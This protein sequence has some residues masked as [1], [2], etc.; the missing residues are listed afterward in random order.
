MNQSQLEDVWPLSPTQQGLLFH[1]LFD[2]RAVDAYTVQLVFD[3]DGPVD[4]RAL[5]AAWEALVRRHANLR[6]A[7]WQPRSGQPVQ[8][9]TRDVTVPWREIDLADL[10][11][12]D[13]EASLARLLRDDRGQRFDL[14]RPPLLRLTLVKVEHQTYRLV[15]THHHILLD[16]WSMQVLTSEL[17]ALYAQHGDP[18]GLAPVTPYRDYLAWLTNQDR[19]G[20]TQAW[21][22]A[23]S[24]LREPTRLGTTAGARTAVVAEHLTIDVP[25]DI[26]A[27]L[28]D[29]ARRLGV[30]LNTVIQGIWGLLLGRLT[31]SRDVVFGAA[32]NGRPPEIPGVATMVG[33]FITTLPVRIRLSPNES[34]S[35]M[36]TRLQDEQ[37]RLSA[38]HHLGLS[39]IQRQTGLGELFDT[40]TVFQNYPRRTDDAATPSGGLRISGVAFESAP[41]YPLSLAAVPMP[42]RRLRLR[43]NY[44][45]DPTDR[46]SRF[47]PPNMRGLLG[48][49]IHLLK[50]IAEDSDRPLKSYSLVSP[51]GSAALPDPCAP[52]VE[53][54]YLPVSDMI[55]AWVRST[56][57]AVAVEH[58]ERRYTYAELGRSADQ[59]A[60]ALADRGLTDGDVVAVYGTPSPGLVAAMLA[61]VSTGGVLLTLDPGLPRHR[62]QLMLE[63]ANARFVISVADIPRSPGPPFDVE[64]LQVLS[65]DAVTAS[66]GVPR[67]LKPSTPD[68]TE[69]AYVFFTSG[70]TGVPKAVVGRH[71]SLS[72]FLVWQRDS[73]GIGPGDRCAQLTGLSFDVLLR[74]VFLPLVSGATLCV[75]VAD[76]DAPEDMI[77]WLASARITCVHAVPTLASAWLQRPADAEPAAT[78]RYAFF[79][80]EA[81]TDHLVS[82]WRQACPNARVINLYGPSETTLAK[83]WY[84]VP[85]DPLPGVQPLGA[86]LPGSQALVLADDQRLCG[87]GEIGE[88]VVRSPYRSLGYLNLP[89]DSP[90]TFVLNKHTSHAADLLYHTG[91]QGRYRLDGGLEFLGRSDRQVKIRGVRIEPDEVAATLATHSAVSQAIVATQADG[92]GTPA[93]IAYLTTT[94]RTPPDVAQL[95]RYLAMR[96]PAAMMPAA[97]VVLDEMP[98]TANGKLDW[99]AL[100]VPSLD[101]AAALSHVPARSPVEEALC[102][103][104]EQ[105][106]ALDGVG[107]HDDFF[108]LGGHSLLAM[109]V[110]GKVRSV[111]GMELPVRDLFEAPTVS[112]LAHRLMGARKGRLALTA[113]ELPRLLPLSF[114]QRRLWF[115]DQLEKGPTYHI[116]VAVRL[117]GVVN[118]PALTAAVSDVVARHESVRTVFPEI[119]G[120]A[121]QRVV[122][123]GPAVPQM[124]EVEVDEA[125]LAQT[126]TALARRAFD[127]RAE[128]PLRVRLLALG[129]QQHVLALVVH[130]IAAD[131]WSMGVLS[132]DLG[133]AYAAR[134]RGEAPR[135]SALSVHYTDYTMWQY[136]LLGEATDPGSLASEQLAYWTAAL[137]ELPDQ[138]ELPA[139]RPRPATATNRGETMAFRLAPELHGRL[140]DVAGR[141]RA[142]L[143]MALQAGLAALLTRLGAGTDIPI[144]SPIAGRT[145]DALDALVGC[146]VNTL[147]LRTDTSGSPSFRELLARVR[148]TNLAAY[149][150]QDLPFEQLVEVL[151]PARSLGRHP[152][153]QVMLALHNG[154]DVAFDLADLQTSLESLPSGSAR[155]DLT[156]AFRQSSRRDCAGV[157]CVVEY[158]T[159]IFDAATVEVLVRRLLRLLAAAVADPDRP[160]DRIDLLSADE[161]ARLLASH[162]ASAFP[163]A[164]MPELFEAQVRA[165]PDLA[166]VV[167]DDATLSYRELNARANRL[168]HALIALGVGPDQ[169]VALALPR[170][171]RLIV[172]IVAVL[173]AGAAY[174]C[175]EPDHPPERTSVVLADAQPVLLLTDTQTGAGVIGAGRI[176][177]L[178]IDAADTL[179]LLAGCADSD[180]GDADRTVPLRAQHLAYAIYTSGSTGQPK[181]VC[182]THGNVANL[183]CHHGE[184]V[185]EIAT[186]RLGG[187]SLR[188]AHMASFSFDVSVYELLWLFAGH[189]LHVV[190]EVTRTDADALMTYIA[191]RRIDHVAAT[192][193]F[194]QSLVARGLLDSDGWQPSVIVIGGEA[195]SE[196]LWNR[197]R[198]AA[199]VDAFNCYGP[200]EYT[201]D[202]TMTEIAGASGPSIGTPI[203]N[204]RA[205]VLDAGL[206]PVPLGVVGQLF[207]GGAGLARGYLGRA[208]LTAERFVADRFGP[209]G[210]RLYRT[211]DLV[212][213]NARGQLDF[214]GRGDDQLQIRGCRVE[215]GEV[216][217][218]LAGHPDLTHAVVVADHGALE[219]RII[220]YIVARPD[221]RPQPAA[222]RA[223]LRQRL[224]E[225]MVPAAFV[226]LDGLPLTPSGKLDRHAL[227]AP[228]V[229]PRRTGRRPR[230]PQE[231]VL[232]EL[233]AEILSVDRVDIDDDFFDLGGH[234]LLA[235][236]LVSRIGAT[237]DITLGVRSL[238][239]AP[240]VA[241]LAMRLD[242]SDP[243]ES[244]EVILP[245]RSSGRRPP[246][247]CIHPGAGLGWA[248]SGLMRY[249]G[250]DHPVYAV[251]ARSLARPEPRPTSLEDM[252]A[253][254]AEQIREVQPSG[255]YCLLGWSVGGLVAHAVATKMQRDGEQIALLAIL[256]AYPPGERSL[257]QSA[258]SDPGADLV[259]IVDM[260]GGHSDGLSTVPLTSARVVD[261]LRRRGSALASLDEKHLATVIA[262]MQNN[263]RL[264][265]NFTPAQ[266]NGN[267][268]VFNC[269]TDKRENAST[270]DAWRPYVNGEIKVH[271]IAAAHNLMTQP[272]SLAEIGPILASA[273]H[274]VTTLTRELAGGAGS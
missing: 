218:V 96:L 194:L 90:P 58:G 245:M 256:D 111:L 148:E 100:P 160:I 159:D 118:K 64:G 15:L 244:F 6:A 110:I 115:L 179:S 71:N 211:G 169:I 125:C 162:D 5:R 132:R 168:A 17:L 10:H 53:E 43:L 72:H 1:S 175:L 138:L 88:I 265:M 61:V 149:A 205:Y 191:Q 273:L 42:D 98:L 204:T 224:P 57:Q 271:D 258:A 76:D 228:D 180:P 189:E 13:R 77:G 223:H 227:P 122:D 270:P 239:E 203:A 153:F 229:D 56:P 145:D 105:V 173:K 46:G 91:D 172:S 221:S 113:R 274:D 114:A 39:E 124:D 18:I 32:I 206:E 178:A 260:F 225:Y 107:V 11:P 269:T 84:E 37:G 41:H 215:L 20:A 230:T 193:S 87:L 47:T 133:I 249:L 200:S 238:F 254:Y 28:H 74:D 119:D 150:H 184:T 167:A 226:T 268:L 202:A 108:D 134:C 44:R 120:V 35:R 21:A 81:L 70:T 144:G 34:L 123:A 174:L 109:Q 93:L 171:A 99:R 208:A 67:D 23:L 252:A 101:S 106:L 55:D 24:G 95:R 30:T 197:L 201:V 176:P 143:F 33:L 137:A 192:P 69:P 49:V 222:L 154:P 255:P 51:D 29:Q 92:E 156:F 196:Q 129:P 78:L 170:S 242:I 248:Y 146:C 152:L 36:F 19:P 220:A 158:A 165:T 161:R 164:T 188:V 264:A 185:F 262:V 131:G 151:D 25:E 267:V 240:T 217:A 121:R 257:E 253:D 73:F 4:A 140:L 187:R 210:A 236:R 60:A 199:G 38:H 63:L 50:Q 181:G 45:G 139:D 89:D 79:A 130:H 127:L 16:G 68:P 66:A 62:L 97:F 128:A 14:A 52:L 136:E 213:W 82:H 141:S 103:I 233:F 83:C 190:D 235:T 177:R 209:P 142:S 85:A 59:I 135:W 212:R 243:D 198:S 112:A 116:A 207:I 216:E 263:G 27:S 234:S 54:C 40:M 231:Q 183:A 163:T 104:V 272:E 250:P 182:V 246:L 232:C 155:F 247:F 186:Q 48:Q 12:A 166:A 219:Q 251:Q 126:L 7:F 157:D 237:F 266:F 86:S 117:S 214:V 9:I 259:N 2:E 80:G 75:P 261:I 3:L 22:E 31:G 26:S 94:Q 241:A 8:A 102:A 65:V 147:V 195:V